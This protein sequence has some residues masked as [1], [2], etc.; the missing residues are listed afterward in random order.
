[1][2]MRDEFNAVIITNILLIFT[3]LVFE[4][5]STITLSSKTNLTHLIYSTLCVCVCIQNYMKLDPNPPIT[6][7]IS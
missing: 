6:G 4:L 2:Y 1:M 3:L 5:I 7:T